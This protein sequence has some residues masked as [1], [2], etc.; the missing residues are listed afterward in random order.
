MILLCKCATKPC[1]RCVLIF[2]PPFIFENLQN[3]MVFLLFI[4]TPFQNGN[5][6]PFWVKKSPRPC[7]F[8]FSSFP[9]PTNDTTN[10]NTYNNKTTQTLSDGVARQRHGGYGLG[11]VRN[12]WKSQGWHGEGGNRGE[13]QHAFWIWAGLGQT[14]LDLRR[15]EQGVRIW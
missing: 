6:I 9:T 7:P 13:W 14:I 5:V 3:K 11:G 1:F 8:P 10:T 2:S 15:M 4:P 12:G